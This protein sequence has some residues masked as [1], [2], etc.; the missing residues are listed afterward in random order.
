MK[1]VLSLILSMITVLSLMPVHMMVSAEETPA[2]GSSILEEADT[3]PA[4]YV[5]RYDSDVSNLRSSACAH[6]YVDGICTLCQE[7]ELLASV[8]EYNWAWK[9]D[10]FGTLTISGTGRM[11]SS[12]WR[13]DY[14]DKIKNV[15]IV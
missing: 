1:H 15:V 2:E 5:G 8:T 14:A 6:Q 11:S 4:E 13:S 9:L 7:T 10:V 12:L 3:F